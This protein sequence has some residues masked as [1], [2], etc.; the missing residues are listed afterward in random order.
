MRA[1]E[2][3]RRAEED[4]DAERGDVD[5][6][7]R[8]VVDGVRPG[9]RTGRVRQLDYTRRVGHRPEGVRGEREG[10][11]AGSIRQLAL[12]VVEV[13]GRVRVDFDKA[14]AEVEVVAELEPR[15]DVAVVVEARDEDLVAGR[16][17]RV[18]ARA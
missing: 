10:D 1:E 13:E 6:R 12:E 3:V 9:E 16:E 2:L 4:V 14:D 11:D 15:R 18:R 8:P 7:V 17:R 5:R